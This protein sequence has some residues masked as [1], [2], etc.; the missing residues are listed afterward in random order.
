MSTTHTRDEIYWLERGGI[1][2]GTG[3]E[4]TDTVTGPT[5]DLTVT[6]YV[7]K[8]G[9]TFV[10]SDSGG[11]GQIGY[12]EEPDIPEEWHEALVNF[13]IS[14]GYEMNPATIQPAGY[15]MTRYGESVM[16]C[17]K[18]KSKLNDDSGYGIYGDQF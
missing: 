14:K 5:G 2:I 9:D 11:S 8:N 7:I 10:D 13:A 4:T 15:F 3:S 12:L 1:A 18:D 16:E 17:K 6:I